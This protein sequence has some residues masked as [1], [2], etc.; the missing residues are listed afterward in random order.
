MQGEW[1]IR[2]DF[3]LVKHELGSGAEIIEGATLLHHL[4]CAPDALVFLD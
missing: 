4:I 2:T 3:I 1:Q